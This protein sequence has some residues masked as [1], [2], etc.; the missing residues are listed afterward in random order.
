[1][2]ETCNGVFI[3]G[4]IRPLYGVNIDWPASYFKTS[5]YLRFTQTICV[6]CVINHQH[7]LPKIYVD[8]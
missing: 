2:L 7:G 4:I 3:T 8:S 6:A 1:M 5:G